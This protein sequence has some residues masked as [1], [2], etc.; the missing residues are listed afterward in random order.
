MKKTFALILICCLLS[1]LFMSIV[2]LAVNA[3]PLAEDNDVSQ[4][5]NSD[6]SDSI[7]DEQDQDEDG[8][9]D[10]ATWAVIGIAIAVAVSAGIVYASKTKQPNK[11]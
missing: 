7:D 1:A 4:S 6:F 9:P 10:W 8:D 11:Q 5:A 2:T 3:D